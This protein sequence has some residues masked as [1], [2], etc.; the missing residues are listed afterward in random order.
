M[1]V[2]GQLT[3]QGSGQ[4]HHCL[5]LAVRWPS[6]CIYSTKRM[7]LL[8]SFRSA[9]WL[10]VAQA[11]GLGFL[12]VPITLA[13]VYRHSAGEEQQ[14]GGH[15]QFHAQHRQQRGNV[16]GD[17]VAGAARAVPPIRAVVSR[18]QVRSRHFGTR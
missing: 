17:D 3:T 2:V 15:D 13:G 12:F 5:R 9:A 14:R 8:I 7:D 4:I 6:G 1:P 16:D 11:F 18:H 10:R